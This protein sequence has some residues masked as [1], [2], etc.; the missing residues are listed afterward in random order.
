MNKLRLVAWCL[1]AALAWPAQAQ[2][3]TPT[4]RP[5][6]T[7]QP[8]ILSINVE[9][10]FLRTSPDTNAQP[11]ASVFEGANFL[12]VGRNADGLWLQVARVSRPQQPL[13]WLRRDLALFSFDLTR[14]P[15]TEAVSGVVGPTPVVDTG[16]AVQILTEANLRLNT[17]FNDTRVLAIV[18]FGLVLPALER[19]PSSSWVKVNYLGTVGWVAEFLVRSSVPL[20]ELP[21]AQDVEGP[22]VILEVIPPEVQ[23]AQAL[24]FIAYAEAQSQ[25]AEQVAAFWTQLQQGLTVAC[26][27]PDSVPAFRQTS[28]DLV[29]LPE[30]RRVTRRLPQAMR[31]LNA[32]IDLM[33]RCGRYSNEEIARALAQ[34]TNAG[35]ILRS[36]LDAMRRIERTIIPR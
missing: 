28:R 18:P 1:C 8:A 21:V 7:P 22:S 4:P 3:S 12:A 31:D 20:K 25:V 5:T 30:L 14:L 36:S 33:R 29:E 19:D 16:F 10:A 15:L 2:T 6:P 13:G 32:S 11:S 26:Q 9:S 34:A 23:R 27:P 17:N 24:R 35:V